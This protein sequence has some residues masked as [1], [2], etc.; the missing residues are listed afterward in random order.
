[1]STMYKILSTI[2]LSRLTPHAQEIIKDHQRGFR[3]KMST[4]DKKFCIRQILQKN[5]DTMK[6]SIALFIDREKTYYSVMREVLYNILI[7]FGV[8]MKLVRLIKMCLNEIYSRV[9]V[10]IH[11]LLR[12]VRF[13]SLLFNSALEKASGRVQVS[14]DSLKLS[15]WLTLMMLIFLTVVYK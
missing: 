7:E 11:F 14:Q 6:Q 13:S 3:R 8:S 10:G 9:R 4:T 15:F 12:M 2:L 5:G 1:L